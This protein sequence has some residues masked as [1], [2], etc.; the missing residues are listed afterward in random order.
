MKTEESLLNAQLYVLRYQSLKSG[1][2]QRQEKI[3]ALQI[4]FERVIAQQRQ[5]EAEIENRRKQFSEQTDQV[6]LVQERFYQLG[7]E[8]TRTEEGLQFNQQRIAQ[9]KEELSQTQHRSREASQQVESDDL[10]I[11][12]M[13]AQVAELQ[14]RAAVLAAADE[15]QQNAL[16]EVETQKKTGSIDGMRLIRICCQRARGAGSDVKN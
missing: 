3:S 4:E 15:S 7:A 5:I 16:A 2:S 1:L 14:P 8:I 6:N 11:Q 10:Q 13:Q 9:L 12:T